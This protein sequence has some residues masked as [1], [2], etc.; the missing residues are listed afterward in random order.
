MTDDEADRLVHGFAEWANDEPSWRALA[1]VGSWARGA[2]RDDSDL[3]LLVL[4]DRLETWAA[5][6]AWL[7]TVV[8]ELG[9]NDATAALEIYGVAKSWRVWLGPRIELELTLRPSKLG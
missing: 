8:A 5:S 6:N 9:F 2:A 3:D 7:R 4:S 1:L